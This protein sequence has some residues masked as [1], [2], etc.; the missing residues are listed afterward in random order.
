MY[1]KNTYIESNNIGP[2]LMDVDEL[3]YDLL[4]RILRYNPKDRISISEAL[5]HPYFKELKDAGFAF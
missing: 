4:M 2:S 5:D 3:A 1:D